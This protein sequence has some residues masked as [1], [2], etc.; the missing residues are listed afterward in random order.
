M[1]VV[2]MLE[3][4]AGHSSYKFL[5]RKPQIALLCSK[6]AFEW[7]DK[8]TDNAFCVASATC[9][10]AQ[11]YILWHCRHLKDALL[12]FAIMSHINAIWK[13]SR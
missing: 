5:H 10:W 8:E 3:G 7:A 11:R 12:P 9:K 2:C 4:S 13:M 1:R 6:V